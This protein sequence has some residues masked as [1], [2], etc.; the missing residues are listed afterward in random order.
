MKTLYEIKFK[1][2]NLVIKNEKLV[3][4][5]VKFRYSAIKD[6]ASLIL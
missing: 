5:M 1:I 4:N 3:D 6:D 2:L